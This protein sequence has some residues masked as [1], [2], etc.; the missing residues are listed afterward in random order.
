MTDARPLRTWR[1][2]LS[3]WTAAHLLP[4]LPHLREL[5]CRPVIRDD[6]L[7]WLG[8]G[9]PPL[10]LVV[11]LFAVALL[12][13][14]LQAVRPR[15]GWWLLFPALLAIDALDPNSMRA[16]G[17]L[18][19]AQWAVLG[20][21]LAVGVDPDAAQVPAWAPRLVVAQWASVYVL[22]VFAKLAEPAWRSGD[23][24]F[25][26]LNSDAHGLFLLSSGGCP[27]EAARWLGYATMALEL[28]MGLCAWSPSTRWITIGGSLAFHAGILA[29]MRIS[30]LF[31]LLMW[32][33]LP[34]VASLPAFR[35]GPPRG[36]SPPGASPG[37]TDRARPPRDPCA[38]G[39]AAR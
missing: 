20:A 26:A 5:Y 9:P 27:H 37:T 33:H 3:A 1:W 17:M 25:L 22:S 30:P 15:V 2:L 7:E 19:T 29:S 36:A 12:G 32:S 14:A 16:Y 18:A 8:A 4:R 11:A 34:L 24:L 35:P 39:A 38:P 10:P 13:L 31:A 23:A 21:L 6:L 28:A